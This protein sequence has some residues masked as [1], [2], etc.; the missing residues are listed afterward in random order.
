MTYVE[1][2]FEHRRWDWITTEGSADPS[3]LSDASE[4]RSDGDSEGRDGP[5]EA[6]G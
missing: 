3:R 5:G 4:G 6:E 2:V 1:E